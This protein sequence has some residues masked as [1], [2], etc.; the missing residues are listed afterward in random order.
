MKYI[1]FSHIARLLALSSCVLMLTSCKLIS[2]VVKLPVNIVKSAARTVG[3]SNLT[4]SPAQPVSKDLNLEAEANA[5]D[6][7]KESRSLD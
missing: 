2:S 3:I 6:S 4:S 1:Q 5:T 7:T